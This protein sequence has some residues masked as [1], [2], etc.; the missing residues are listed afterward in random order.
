M[1]RLFSRFAR[2]RAV[3][4]AAALA[5]S[6]ACSER[7]QP[8][9]A[10]LSIGQLLAEPADARFERALAPRELHFP[11]DHGPHPSFQVEWW[12][13][14]GNL[15]DGEGRELSYQ[16]TFFRRALEF[17]RVRGESQWCARDAYLAHFTV[18]DASGAV[19]H[20]F[21]RF[22]RDALGL[23]GAQAQPWRVWSRD[24]SASGTLDGGDVHLVA[25][26]GDNALD[27]VVHADCPPVPNGERGLS[28]KGTEQGQASY[29]YSIPRMTTRGTLTIDGRAH[30]VHGL[31]WFDREW[32]TCVLDAGQVGWDWFALRIDDGSAL[33]LYRLRNADG[34]AGAF[35]SG[36][37]I[38]SD[39]RA[40]TLAAQDFTIEELA[41]W[42]SPR[43]A[44]S[45]P[46]RW[47]VTLREPARAFEFASTLA[48]SELRL[49]VRYWEGAVR[50][51][52]VRGFVELTGY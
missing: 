39:G 51:E 32:S 26:A 22:D 16:L 28:R 49:T 24:W 7:A 29:Y 46:S 36:T 18:G 30:E 17:E 25:R 2:S 48:D 10:S 19:F 21:E 5:A 8:V 15:D 40:T 52:H 44:A 35:A 9:R 34:S 3:L 4:F 47:R 1:G 41:H 12:Y 31:S 33:M 27:L 14:T 38:A 37:F 43:S 11:V 45:Y 6:S 42:T 50:G 20:A 23:S 13:F